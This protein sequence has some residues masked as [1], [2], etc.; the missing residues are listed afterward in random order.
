MN[1]A[2]IHRLLL[3]AA[4]A[5]A[6]TSCVSTVAVIDEYSGFQR[7]KG[8]VSIRLETYRVPV[9]VSDDRRELEFSMRFA[10]RNDTAKPWVVDASHLVAC[11]AP[12]A[13]GDLS[14]IRSVACAAGLGTLITV[15]PRNESILRTPVRVQLDPATTID[16][17]VQVPVLLTFSD[18]QGEV[19]LEREIQVGQ[20]TK[21]G[22]F[23]RVAVVLTGVMFLL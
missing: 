12:D 1:A 17:L 20:F 14:R 6:W 11:L 15:P 5:A 21:T 23:M 18:P 9:E 10:L 3:L 4:L 8:D 13:T 22:Q 19:L 16:D 7:A 2:P